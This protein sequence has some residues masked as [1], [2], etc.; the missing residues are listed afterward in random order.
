[1][2]DALF[3]SQRVYN[4]E[5]DI[6]QWRRKGKAEEQRRVRACWKRDILVDALCVEIYIIYIISQ[7]RRS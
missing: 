1:M 7:N 3:F 2:A 4:I 5:K 6:E